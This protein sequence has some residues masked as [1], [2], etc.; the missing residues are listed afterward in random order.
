MIS[1]NGRG[2]FMRTCTKCKL[3]KPLSDFSPDRRKKSGLQAAC[4]A[5]ANLANSKR[6]WSN[7]STREKKAKYDKEY[8]KKNRERKYK[9]NERYTKENPHRIKAWRRNW[10]SRNKEKVLAEAN[11]RRAKKLNATP[12]WLSEDQKKDIERVYKVSVLMTIITGEQ[13]HVDHI[14]PLRGKDVCGLHVSWHLQ[15]IP[16]EINLKKG[17]D[18]G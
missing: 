13:Y 6:Y 4:R 18:H 17:N 11:D 9:N 16:A 7:P 5:C 2:N 15:A 12:C 8:L 14:V 3:N 10:R 1:M